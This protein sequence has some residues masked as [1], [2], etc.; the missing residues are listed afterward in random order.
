[1]INKFKDFLK[2]KLQKKASKDL[3]DQDELLDDDSFGSDDQTSATTVFEN[4]GEF[5]NKLNTKTT[6]TNFSEDASF[7]DIENEFKKNDSKKYELSD[8]S[9][10]KDAPSLKEKLKEKFSST[11]DA[12]KEKISGAKDRF[13]SRKNADSETKLAGSKLGS[14]KLDRTKLTGIK[15]L[16]TKLKG[17]K[18]AVPS[19][20][21]GS[22]LLSPSLT[23]SIEKFL[24]RSYRE[25][26]HQ[27]ALVLLICSLT[28]TAGK[29]TALVMRGDPV[30]DSAKDFTVS[31]PIENS[32]NPATLGQVK[33]I[34]IFRTNNQGSGKKTNVADKKC[35]EAEQQ[36]SL[37]IK[38]VNT[39]VLQD[40][41]KSIA[42]VQ[43]RGDREL[44]ELRV[45]DQIS[46]LAEIFRITRLEILVK[47]LES[48]MCES[49]ASDLMTKEKTSPISVLSPAQSREFKANK[50]L[51]GIDNVG[52]KFTIS[53]AL[54]DE[55]LQDLGKILTQAKAVQI[56]NP[57]GSLAFKMTELDPTGIFGYLG[58][59][60]G[61]IITSINGKPIYNM[62]EVM[63]LFGRIKGL[64]TLSL[65]IK[66]EGTDTTQDYSIK[67]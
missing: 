58:V 12:A 60:D 31:V 38:L 47:N 17:F 39:V 56:N 42:S 26:I 54:L 25:P 32:F 5:K 13:A 37:P 24:S 46:N 59:Q 43:I 8:T 57:D 51:S 6:T 45:G 20:K 2:K 19:S 28:Y 11:V 27:V 50:K 7:I 66:R 62:N 44:Q 9:L 15:D 23:R 22:P 35:E 41:V 21:D 29:I 1:M 16:G 40:I 4:T 36:S 49:I 65:G 64:E 33:S 3:S 48:G 14:L 10:I 61:D 53:K 67:K 34:N 18:L 63:L 55:K 52:N 30:L